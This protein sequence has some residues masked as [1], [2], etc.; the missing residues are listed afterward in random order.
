VSG[1]EPPDA[2]RDDEEVLPGGV[3]NAGQVVRVG[4]FVLRPTSAH[5]PVIH[6]LLRHVRGAGFDGVPEVVGVD[7][8]GRERL[9]YIEGDVPS[10]PYP[11]WS[12]TD[13][14]LASMAA[15]LRRY[16]EAA[17]GFVAP[18]GMTWSDELADPAG[19]TLV[20]HNDVCPEN[21]VFRD[22]VAVA[23]LD[24][25]FAAPG[26]PLYDLSQLA[27]MNVPLDTPEDALRTRGHAPDVFT[28]LRVVADAYGLPPGRAEFLAVLAGSMDPVGGL[29]ERRVARGE[30]AFIEMWEQMG[31]R[32]RYERRQ[33]WFEAQRARFADALG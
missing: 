20:C 9:V 5:T 7:P 17:A 4:E 1:R 32:A 29:V 13:D 26:R 22:G 27:K 30:P 15:L 11:A 16:H 6:A 12:L 33:A 21:V 23:L 31:G 3:G 28:R 25:E 19:G 2:G 24:F 14:A 18:P 8:D 10:L